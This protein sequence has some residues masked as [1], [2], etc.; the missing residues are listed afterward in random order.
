MTTRRLLQMIRISFLKNGFK[1]AEYLK[2]KKVF[3]SMG[4]HCFWQPRNIPPE[5]GLI[6]IGNNVAIASC[7]SPISTQAV[8]ISVQA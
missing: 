8:S 6:R 3:A 2:K 7:R 4:E 5:T 1:R